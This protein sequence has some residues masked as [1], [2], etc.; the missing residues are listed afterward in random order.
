MTTSDPEKAR[1]NRL[2]GIL[3]HFYCNNC[4]TLLAVPLRL[5]KQHEEAQKAAQS[6][7]PPVFPATGT[8]AAITSAQSSSPHLTQP[9]PGQAFEICSPDRLVPTCSGTCRDLKNDF[10]VGVC[11]TTI[12]R[13]LCIDHLH[14]LNPRPITDRKTLCLRDLIFLRAII[15]AINYNQNPLNIHT[16]MY[17][18]SGPNAR[19][20]PITEIDPWSY[21]SHV[22]RPINYLQRLLADTTT[23]QWILLSQLD[24]WIIHALLAKISK[25]MRVSTSPHYAKVYST[26]NTI[27]GAFGPEHPRWDL[28]T[29]ILKDKIVEEKND[30]PVWSAGID[31]LRDLIRVADPAKGESPNVEVVQKE[32]LSVV[33]VKKQGGGEQGSADPAIKAGEPLLRAGDEGDREGA[34]LEMRDEEEEQ[35]WYASWFDEMMHDRFDELDE[36][37]EEEGETADD[38]DEEM[39]VDEG[40]DVLLEGHG[41]TAGDAENIT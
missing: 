9:P 10:D 6:R 33:A 39:F 34:D 20:I 3:D 29:Q 19:N 27:I 28:V 21:T 11:G 12:A 7:V 22:V 18:T 23:D 30:E 5:V 35:K 4:A 17:A 32:G 40:E 36:G 1:K 26:E 31:S 24:G 37:D 13:Q 25:A 14:Y 41:D 16:I 38:G 8:A 2:E 15:I